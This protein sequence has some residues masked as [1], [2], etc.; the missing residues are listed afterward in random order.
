MKWK[1]C[2]ADRIP[3]ETWTIFQRNYR[4]STLRWQPCCPFSRRRLVSS[5]QVTR[6]ADSSITYTSPSVVSLA[7]KS[8]YFRVLPASCA[9]VRPVLKQQMRSL[10]QMAQLEPQ[11]AASSV[12]AAALALALSAAN[13]MMTHASIEQPA[14]VRCSS[15]HRDVVLGLMLSIPLVFLTRAVAFAWQVQ[16]YG[17]SMIAVDAIEAS[18]ADLREAQKKFLE[19]RAKLKQ[20]YEASTDSTY[21]GADETGQKKNIYVT[22]VGGLIVLAFVVPMLQFFYYTGG[23]VAY[24]CA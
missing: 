7:D 8:R 12:V 11:R 2:H 13:P 5:Y 10:P 1:W 6:C 3:L 20:T 22:I 23:Y 15:G 21:K 16:R 4:S 19:E 18:D 9:G 24:S 17:G 14:V